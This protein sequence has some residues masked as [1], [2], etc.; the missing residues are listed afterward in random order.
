MEEATHD[1]AFLEPLAF[2]PDLPPVMLMD[3]DL[4]AGGKWG[5]GSSWLMKTWCRS[6]AGVDE[7]SWME[8]EGDVRWGGLALSTKIWAAVIADGRV[9]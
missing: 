3:L 7:K 2:P 8:E 9:A 1:C 4:F 6:R 5:D